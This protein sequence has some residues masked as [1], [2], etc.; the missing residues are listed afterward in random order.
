MRWAP[1][2]SDRVT[3]GSR[4]SGTTATVTP[5]ANR[6]PS[7]A[8]IPISRATAKKVTPTP[9]ATPAMTRDARANSRRSGV[10]ACRCDWLRAAIAASRVCAPVL[11]TCARASPSTTKL[12]ANNVSP[13]A[14]WS[15][16]L[17]PVSAEVSTER[18]ATLSST[19]VGRDPV[20]FGEQHQIAHHQLLGGDL[21]GTAV[22]HHRGPPRKHLP[23]PLC[24]VLGAF[25][26]REREQPVENHDDEDRDA[27]LRK[28]CEKR[29]CA[30]HPEQQRKEVHH[31][32]SQAPPPR[33]GALRRKAIGAVLGQQPRGVLGRQP[34]IGDLW[35][36]ADLAHTPPTLSRPSAGIGNQL[37][38]TV[39]VRRRG[40]ARHA[41]K[42]LTGR[43]FRP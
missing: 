17:S 25:L 41:T 40:W 4:P 19:D 22:A 9:I 36:F 5:T 38:R 14:G 33:S 6:K 23:E 3:V 31:F 16:T 32:C 10:G 28:A 34:G 18:P 42:G 12:P 37:R 11:T 30:G 43:D 2:A 24:G 1:M 20:A 13:A 29:Q 7:A 35:R 21:P 8:G 26:L 39:T 15:G 27:Q